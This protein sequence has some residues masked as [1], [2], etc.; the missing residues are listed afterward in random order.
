MDLRPYQVA[1]TNNQGLLSR[2]WKQHGTVYAITHRSAALKI[3]TGDGEIVDE[4]TRRDSVMFTF[5]CGLFI[6]VRL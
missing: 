3:Y 1:S 5:S 2:Q 4:S 6:S